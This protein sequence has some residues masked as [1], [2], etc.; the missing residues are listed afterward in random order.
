[1]FDFCRENPAQTYRLHGFIIRDIAAIRLVQR[2]ALTDRSNTS[3][4]ENMNVNDEFITSLVMRSVTSYEIRDALME[5]MLRPYLGDYTVHFCHEL[6]N[7]AN[8]PY[9]LI[10]YDRNVRYS[11]PGNTGSASI[12]FQPHPEFNVK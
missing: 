10:G 11:T 12:F 9:D 2:L 6:Y 8:S 3:F 1:L 5:G 7:Y 4:I